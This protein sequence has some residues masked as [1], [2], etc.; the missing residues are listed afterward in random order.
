M[1]ERRLAKGEALALYHIQHFLEKH[2]LTLHEKYLPPVD[3][4]LA[5]AD[6]DDTL[7]LPSV[8]SSLSSRAKADQLEAKLNYQQKLVFDTIIEAVKSPGEKRCFFLQASGGTGKTFT[9]S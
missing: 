4:D 5:Q 1:R 8:P 9:Y 7:D 6:I 3:M 2:N